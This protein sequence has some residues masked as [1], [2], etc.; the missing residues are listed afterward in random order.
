[1]SKPDLTRIF[2]NNSSSVYNAAIAQGYINEENLVLAL[3]TIKIAFMFDRIT[4]KE[5]ETLQ[6]QIVKRETFDTT[7]L[8]KLTKG[9]RVVLN[10]INPDAL[11]TEMPS[12]TIEEIQSEVDWPRYWDTC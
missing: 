8:A 5:K 2:S 10:E 7:I 11:L 12:E 6:N 9:E 3:Q 4:E 1:M